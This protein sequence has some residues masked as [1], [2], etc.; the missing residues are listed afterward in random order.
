MTDLI[1]PSNFPGGGGGGDSGSS[2]WSI[3]NKLPT[4]RIDAAITRARSAEMPA[5]GVQSGGYAPKFQ[6]LSHIPLLEL[7]S[8][9][10]HRVLARQQTRKDRLIEEMDRTD[11]DKNLTKGQ[12]VFLS[13]LGHA[14]GAGGMVSAKRWERRLVGANVYTNNMLMQQNKLIVFTRWTVALP[15][16]SPQAAAPWFVDVLEHRFHHDST[17]RLKSMGGNAVTLKVGIGGSISGQKKINLRLLQTEA[18]GL[19][20]QQK[21][22]KNMNY[23]PCEAVNYVGEN[24]IVAMEIVARIERAA[25]SLEAF[26]IMKRFNKHWLVPLVQ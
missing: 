7:Y 21:W 6:H 9:E 19:K 25:S 23:D 3:L 18:R 24:E 20:T 11:P 5:Q 8:D 10:Q 17:S 12:K 1:D 15:P 4:K 14:T 13:V 16:G 2:P 26:E 22:S